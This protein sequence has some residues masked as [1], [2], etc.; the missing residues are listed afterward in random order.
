L[1]RL[2]T[3]I[4]Y[5]AANAVGRELLTFIANSSW[6]RKTAIL[7]VV[8]AVPAAVLLLRVWQKRDRAHATLRSSLPA[9]PG[10]VFLGTY[11]A[12]FVNVT[13]EKS[14]MFMVAWPLFGILLAVLGCAI[15][16]FAPVEDRF[17][18]LI[19]NGLL[20]VLALV[21]IVAPN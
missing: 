6:I 2:S 12:W 18:L 1:S 10:L 19:S 20:L 13:L 14:V 7:S 3:E 4:A 9:W 11:V 21:S 17:K 15:S 16:F 5:A 8:L